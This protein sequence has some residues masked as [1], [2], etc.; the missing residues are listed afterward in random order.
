MAES[1]EPS[2]GP[3]EITR[4]LYK[5]VKGLPEEEQRTVF[6]YFF[7]RGIGVPPQ[8]FLGRF[9]QERVEQNLEPAAWTGPT[10]PRTVNVKGPLG[11]GH[12]MVPVRLSEAQHRRLKDWCAEHNFPMAVVIRG[13]VERFLDDWERRAA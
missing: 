10:S 6:E 8:P 7:E 9:L 3:S 1:S 12:Q 4:L 2:R 11:P 13:L 5:A